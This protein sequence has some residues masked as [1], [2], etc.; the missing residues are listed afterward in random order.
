MWDTG[1]VFCSKLP[2]RIARFSP[3]TNIITRA[4]AGVE[5]GRKVD[6]LQRG[7]GVTGLKTR[8][9]DAGPARKAFVQPEACTSS[10][11]LQP[12]VGRNCPTSRLPA[13]VFADQS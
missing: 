7:F 6:M 10:H 8:D 11:P 12:I 4:D 13:G 2:Y 9:T 1:E 5:A 3:S